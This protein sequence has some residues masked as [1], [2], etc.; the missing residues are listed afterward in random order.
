MK[1]LF[2]G[3][4][5]YPYLSGITTY[6]L[7]LLSHFANKHAVTALTFNH[8]EN[9]FS[10]ETIKNIHVKRMPYLLKISKGYISFKS[11]K[12]F[13]QEVQK[14]DIV[15]LN[16]PNA[17]GLILALLAKI[18]KKKVIALFHCRVASGNDLLSKIIESALNVVV[19]WQL[20][21]SDKI[22]VYTHDYFENLFWEK[23]FRRK[24][25]QV[26]PPVINQKIDTQFYSQLDQKK[27]KK[28]WIGFAGRV[29]REKGIEYLIEALSKLVIPQPF[30]LVFAGPFGDQVVGENS[31]YK[32]IKI[33]L[34]KRKIPHRFLGT[35]RAGK[36]RAFYEAVDVL[37]LPSI[38]GTEAFGM[39]QIEAMLAGTPVVVS[40][41]PGV[42]VPVH[43]TGMGKVVPP[44]DVLRLR[45]ALKQVLRNKSEFSTLPMK[46]TVT[47]TFSSRQ[48]FSFFD[49]LLKKYEV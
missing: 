24:T 45:R 6:P 7:F 40:D 3:T 25:E 11:W 4:Y 22:I 32:T 10:E 9:T 27:E 12:Y 44:K 34:E 1:I 49:G 46:N 23:I 41:L 5:F 8:E 16:I 35:L 37:V 47:K 36:L 43:A 48:T 17:E 39:V 15:F 13:F 2:F 28:Y 20:F 29:S 31:Y 38:N 33:L 26:Y 30:E 19:W 21:L 18:L 14:N 42:R